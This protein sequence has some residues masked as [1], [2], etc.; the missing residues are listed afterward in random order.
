MTTTTN[1]PSSGIMGTLTAGVNRFVRMI[2]GASMVKFL[3]RRL[4]AAIPVLFAIMLVTFTLSHL[5]PGGPFAAVGQK[6]I[7]FPR[8]P[9]C[10]AP[11][12]PGRQLHALAA[13]G[14]LGVVQQTN[15]R[16]DTEATSPAAR[17]A[18][19][20]QQALG[21]HDEGQPRLQGLDLGHHVPPP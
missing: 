19:V 6:R 20:R 10:A 21:L 5:L 11:T 13:H 18:R 8:L 4:L 17:A 1:Q 14:D 12:A 15:A 7:L 3:I 16:L 9:V 2:G